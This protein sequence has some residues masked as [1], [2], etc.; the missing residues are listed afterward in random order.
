MH[1]F[2]TCAFIVY[3]TTEITNKMKKVVIITTLMV[4]VSSFLKA[5]T[6][7]LTSTHKIV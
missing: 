5:I 6:Y 2:S 3:L 4:L 7:N 1:S